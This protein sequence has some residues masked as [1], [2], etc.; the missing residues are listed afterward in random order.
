MCLYFDC[1]SLDAVE[2]Q[3]RADLRACFLRQDF[4]SARLQ[5]VPARYMYIIQPLIP[6]IN[7]KHKVL[8]QRQNIPHRSEAAGGAA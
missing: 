7:L 8:C 1:W 3:L 2:L 6:A 5:E 4:S